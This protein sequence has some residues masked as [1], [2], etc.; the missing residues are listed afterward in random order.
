[1]GHSDGSSPSYPKKVGINLVKEQCPECFV[2]NRTNSIANAIVNLADCIDATQPSTLWQLS[3]DALL[4]KVRNNQLYTMYPAKFC[5]GKG[6]SSGNWC[7]LVGDPHDVVGRVFWKDTP[8]LHTKYIA[9]APVCEMADNLL[10]PTSA[11]WCCLYE[12]WL[13][14]GWDFCQLHKRWMQRCHMQQ[15]LDDSTPKSLPVADATEIHQGTE[16]A[17][18]CATTAV[19]HPVNLFKDSMSLVTTASSDSN[20]E[21]TKSATPQ[22]QMTQNSAIPVCEPLPPTYTHITLPLL[23]HSSLAGSTIPELQTSKDVTETKVNN[24]LTLEEQL[25]EMKEQQAELAAE[26]KIIEARLT[27]A[28]SRITASEHTHIDRMLKRQRVRYKK[29]EQLS[30]K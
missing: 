11:A 16:R 14:F 24:I 7:S 13:C 28:S 10:L 26:I 17:S 27:E 12:D 23:P 19:R 15:Q 5:G 21:T 2:L 29:L 9:L 1:M 18:N 30:K 6:K 3:M 4:E 8:S 22:S 25:Y 20:K